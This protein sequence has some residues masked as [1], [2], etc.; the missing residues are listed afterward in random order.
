MKNT[1]LKSLRAN[2]DVAAIALLVALLAPGV[3][4]ANSR[5]SLIFTADRSARQFD[6]RAQQ[7]WQRLED[8]MRSFEDRFQRATQ[9]SRRYS[10][11]L[12]IAA[13]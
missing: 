9:P 8:R 5:L 6:V 12:D 10:E 1:L 13:E 2:P 3:G 7:L 4:Q 11:S